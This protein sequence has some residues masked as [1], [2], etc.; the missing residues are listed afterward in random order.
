[1]LRQSQLEGPISVHVEYVPKADAKESLA[2]LK[3]DFET[4]RSSLSE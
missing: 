2:A 3:R 1:M 4:L